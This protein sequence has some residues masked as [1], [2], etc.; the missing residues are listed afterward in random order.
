SDIHAEP[1]NLLHAHEVPLPALRWSARPSSAWTARA[2]AARSRRPHPSRRGAVRLLLWSVFFCHSSLLTN[3]RSIV[4]RLGEVGA[5][6]APAG[7]AP[8][9]KN[10]FSAY[11]VGAGCSVG[12][13]NGAKRS[14]RARSTLR[15]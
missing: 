4:F 7:P 3:F 11:A 6:P 8:T 9:I 15:G 5:G 2:T 12:G 10:R 13:A 1:A 14:A